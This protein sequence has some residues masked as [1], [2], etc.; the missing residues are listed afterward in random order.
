MQFILI[1]VAAT[2]AVLVGYRAFVA[3]ERHRA[4]L[5]T[6]SRRAHSRGARMV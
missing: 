3:L 2:L 6:V 4:Q 1:D 5:T